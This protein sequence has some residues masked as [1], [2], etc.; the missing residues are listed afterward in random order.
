ML[1]AQ[2]EGKKISTKRLAITPALA[3]RASTAKAPRK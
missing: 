2:I 1:V 3:I